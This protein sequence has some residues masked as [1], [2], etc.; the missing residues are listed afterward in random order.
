M[1]SKL[2]IIAIL[3]QI[4]SIT[5]GVSPLLSSWIKTNGSTKT[6]NG[7]TYTTDVTGIYYS[8][9]DVYVKGQGIP[10]YSIGPWSSNPNTPSGP[11]WVFIF[12]LNQT[13]NTVSTNLLLSLGQIGAWS[14]AMAIYGP[15]DGVSYASAGIWHRNALV[16]EGISFDQCYGHPDVSGIYHNHVIPTC[17]YNLNNS[18]AHSPILGFAFDGYPIYGPYGYVNATNSNSD[19]KLIVSGYTTR[20]SMTVRD[21]TSSNGTTLSGTNVGP[22]VNSTY[23]LGSFIEDFEWSASNGDLD[24]NNGRWYVSILFWFL[25]SKFFS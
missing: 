21:K 6:Y 1:N 3:L 19:L 24:A 25:I 17:L 9:T 4:I 2:L 15:Y 13:S 23:P 20:A 12:P 5:I 18:A 22:P 10:S 8:S 11:S 7:V 16:Y 14:N